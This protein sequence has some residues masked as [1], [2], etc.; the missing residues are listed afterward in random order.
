MCFWIYICQ[1]S[2]KHN[3]RMIRWLVYYR[4]VSSDR[5]LFKLPLFASSNKQLGKVWRKTTTNTSKTPI[6]SHLPNRSNARCIGL[7]NTI[8]KTINPRLPFD[9]GTL[10]VDKFAVSWLLDLRLTPG[11]AFVHNQSTCFSFGLWLC[12][13]VNVH[14]FWVRATI[15]TRYAVSG[16]FL[17]IFLIKQ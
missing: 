8:Y 11:T 13:S 7:Y 15:S 1:S 2:S 10:G 5:L 6:S 12:V 3:P 9:K 16:R 17:F 14:P 4:A